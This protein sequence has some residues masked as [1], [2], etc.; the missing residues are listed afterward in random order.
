MKLHTDCHPDPRSDFGGFFVCD[1]LNRPRA[2]GFLQVLTILTKNNTPYP[3]DLIKGS[4][5]LR[6]K[7]GIRLEIFQTETIFI[8]NTLIT[9][10]RQYRNDMPQYVKDKH[11]AAQQGKK[12]TE[13][14]KEKISQSMKDYWWKL[15]FKPIDQPTS[16]R[17]SYDQYG[18]HYEE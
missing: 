16:G 15:P 10:K 8:I 5:V 14:T 2:L 9:M 4:P 12:H 11:A 7:F 17:T 13:E 3:I 1:I 18:N 6:V